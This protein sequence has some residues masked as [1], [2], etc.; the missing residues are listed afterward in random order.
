MMQITKSP[1][2]W[3]VDWRVL[4]DQEFAI[5]RCL[6]TTGSLGGDSK[7][8]PRSGGHVDI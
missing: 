7:I 8:L 5:R 2:E 6:A 4:S 3:I 1:N